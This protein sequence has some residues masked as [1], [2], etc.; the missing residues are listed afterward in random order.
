MFNNWITNLN[1]LN[2]GG[3]MSSGLGKINSNESRE[4][5]EIKTPSN[6]AKITAF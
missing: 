3:L 4:F 1:T 6:K 2:G 5:L